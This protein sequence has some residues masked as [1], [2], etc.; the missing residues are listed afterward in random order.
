MVGNENGT[1][2]PRGRHGYGRRAKEAFVLDHIQRLGMPGSRRG[3]GG[4]ARRF[5]GP[6]KGGRA[7]ETFRH[8]EIQTRCPSAGFAQ[9]TS[10]AGR[11]CRLRLFAGA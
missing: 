11:R 10:H 6:W 7:W 5:D 2:S 3:R 1:S 9:G 4:F 8:P